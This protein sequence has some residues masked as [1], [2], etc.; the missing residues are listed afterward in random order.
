M[1]FQVV[2]Q[3]VTGIERETGREGEKGYATSLT[4]QQFLNN[5]QGGEK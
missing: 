4:H 2:M 1:Y 3:F 5:A